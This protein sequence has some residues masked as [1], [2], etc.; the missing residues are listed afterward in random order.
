M[1]KEPAL[2]S[3]KLITTYKG[4]ALGGLEKLNESSRQQHENVE[5]VGVGGAAPPTTHPDRAV[6][7]TGTP[8][9]AAHTPGGLQE[10]HRDVQ[11]GPALTLVHWE[12]LSAVRND[13]EALVQHDTPPRAM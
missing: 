10:K 5:D 4:A 12:S 3:Q 6:G 11:E 7:D 1:V 2:G 8:L 9:S 13:L